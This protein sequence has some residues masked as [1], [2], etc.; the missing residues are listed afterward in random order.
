MKEAG[1]IIGLGY[2]LVDAKIKVHKNDIFKLPDN[3]TN[4]LSFLD[5]HQEHRLAVGGSTPN[6]MTAY[7][8]F[9]RNKHV[10]LIGAVGMDARGEFYRQGTDKRLGELQQSKTIPTGII[11]FLINKDGI[12]IDR[13]SFYGAATTVKAPKESYKDEKIALFVTNSVV[14]RHQHVISELNKI[15]DHVKKMQGIIALNLT[16]TAQNKTTTNILFGGLSSINISPQIVVGNELEAQYITSQ[17]NS[18]E[19]LASLFPNSRLV[20]ITRDEHGS[21][22]RFDNSVINIPAYPC[23]KVI[24][25]TGAGDAFMGILLGCLFEK[26][27]NKWSLSDVKKAAFTASYG[28]SKVVERIETRLEP[29]QFT[30]IRDYY[31]KIQEI[32]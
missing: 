16:G 11:A 32:K 31:K 20:A 15:T 19:A 5:Q 21:M 4:L 10:S 12:A 14:F 24:D 28:A 26:P 6:T 29:A 1:K 30:E 9:S 17:S 7:V 2:P 3:P 25:S 8:Q 23:S 13:R 18:T 27:Y 22:L